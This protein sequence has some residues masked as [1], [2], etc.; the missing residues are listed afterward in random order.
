MGSWKS[1]G[2]PSRRQDSTA[3]LGLEALGEKLSELAT[4]FGVK[5]TGMV[6][7]RQKMRPRALF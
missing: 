1:R 7:M 3:W 2:S 6:F 5:N 4:I